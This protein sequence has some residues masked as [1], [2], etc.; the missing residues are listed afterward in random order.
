LRREWEKG[1]KKKKQNPVSGVVT[2]PSGLIK[3]KR[4]KRPE[5]N[6]GRRKSGRNADLRRRGGHEKRK[7][8][9]R[10]RGKKSETFMTDWL[11]R[12]KNPKVREARWHEDKGKEGE[13]L[14]AN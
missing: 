12:G 3:A 11:A 14:T 10:G 9:R 7:I 5:Q 2:N 13:R 4:K 8:L 6:R 1:K